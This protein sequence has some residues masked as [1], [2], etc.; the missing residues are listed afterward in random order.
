[1]PHPD[2][3]PQLA[4]LVA[5]PPSGDEWLH[6]I[7]YDGYR[8]G[9]RVR[10]GRVT[11]YTRN[12]ND[13]TAAFPE[14]A[15]AIEKLGLD[16]A[17]IDGEAAMVLPDGRTSFQAMQN[18][19]DPTRRGTLVY[20]VFDLLRLNGEA[21]QS[22]PLHE[23]KN[24]LKKLVGARKTGLIRYSEHID[25]NGDA[26]F[27][28]ACRAGLEGIVSKRRDQPH[29]AGRHGGW[30]KTKCV[31]RQ[32]FVIGG[33]TDPEGMRAGIGALL[34]GYHEGGRLIFCGKVGTGFTHK[35][36]L[37]LRA[38]LDRI[39]VNA[40]PFIPPPSGSLGR[41]AH[42][43]KPELVCEV[44]FTEWTTDGKIRHPSFQGLRKDKDP[45]Q[46]VRERVADPKGAART[47]P[48][49]DT[50]AGVQISHPDRVL[51]PDLELTKLDIA[52]Y[53]QTVAD[54]VV[55]HV[56]G[57]PLTLVRCP[58][59]LRG[60]CFF[61]KHSKVWAPSALRRVRIKEKTK[62]GEY[63]IADDIAGVVGLVQMGVLE[64]HTWNSQF[65]DV[66]R[67]NRIVFDLDPGENVEWPSVVRAARLVRDT[68]AAL[69]LESWV[70]TTGGRGLH[71]VVPL[72]PH[73]DWA[74]CLDFSRALSGRFERAQPDLYTTAFAKTGRERKILVDYLR[75]NRTN[76]SIAAYSTRARKGA[77]VSI[78]LSWEEL[79]I[80]LSPQSFTVL[81]VAKRLAKLKSDPWA[82]YW[83]CKQRL[84][85]Q[86]I[87]AVR[88]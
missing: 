21:L 40:P 11:L 7:K 72:T 12:G 4:T 54:W 61:M 31:Q 53:F 41:N 3:Q 65:E 48:A 82:S 52:R 57:R 84:T 76:T 22:Q 14:I 66:E 87:R 44:V 45:R 73:A 56:A 15:A 18:A 75:N 19:G 26:F 32:E 51:Y 5:T 27:S 30:V 83:K 43:V 24:L 64:I 79:R 1:M 23:R 29:Q 50:I 33:F 70:K 37:D 60:E 78:P 80:T 81:T 68:L 20:F 62:L 39:E 59:G 34:I 77:P 25:G 67:P 86:L 17:L 69:Q 46:I 6:E 58:E 55:P 74:Q 36:T 2:Y 49:R 42:W 63:L 28:E 38:T 88:E 8:I 35:M 47:A 9:A 16:D 85:A 13:W 10:K 71:I